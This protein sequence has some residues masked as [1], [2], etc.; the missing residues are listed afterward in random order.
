M[1]IL[2]VVDKKAKSMF[3]ELVTLIYKDDK[4][5]VRPLDAQIEEIFNPAANNFF[6]H[7]EAERFILVNDEG[8]TI[9]RVAAFINTKKAMA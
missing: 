3:L 2:P 1:K 8:T 5:Y 6:T 9:G 4:A 7:G